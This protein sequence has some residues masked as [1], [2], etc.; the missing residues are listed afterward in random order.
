MRERLLALVS[1]VIPYA[2]LLTFPASCL[3]TRRDNLRLLNLIEAV[4]FLHQFQ[5]P[6]KLSETNEEQIEATVD[7]YAIA[8]SLAISV[9]GFGLD[10]LRKPVCDLLAVIVTNL[11]KLADERGI[12]PQAVQFTR[13]EV[14][15]W[16]SLPNHQVKQGMH[17]LEEME[18]LEVTKATRGSR[19]N[20]HLSQGLVG[21]WCQLIQ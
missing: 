6:H 12:Q 13:R 4:A 17:E 16:T 21:V 19:F 20:Y 2:E 11:Q 14:R 18:Y 8:Y 7:D 15:A 5:R 10:E 9:L 3:R 1:V